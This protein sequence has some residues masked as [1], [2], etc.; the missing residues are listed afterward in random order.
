[1]N[2]L[3]IEDQEDFV[4]L[5]R[6]SAVQQG[7]NLITLDDFGIHKDEPIV[8]DGSLEEQLQKKFEEHDAKERISVVLLDT[9]LMQFRNQVSHSACRTALQSLGIPVCRYSKKQRETEL[10]NARRL[11]TIATEGSSSMLVPRAVIS[12]TDT[13]RLVDWLSQVGQSF[14]ALHKA[15]Q[16]LEGKAAHQGP[17]AL[18]AEI[19]GHP[20]ARFDFVGYTAQNLFFFG[21]QL[22]DE[23]TELE[24]AERKQRRL[25]TQLGYWLH[26]YILTFPGPILNV[27]AAAALLNLSEEALGIPD[28]DALLAP[29]K[30]AGPFSGLQSYYWANGVIDATAELDAPVWQD[31]KYAAYV[32]DSE[33]S[34]ENAQG[35]YCVLSN[36]AIPAAHAAAAPDW[37]PSGARMTR[38]EQGIYDKLSPL[39]SI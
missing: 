38:V 7:H 3:H 37:I 24:T 30:Y 23:Q 2:I 33:V 35:Y 21:K 29:A 27:S 9:D 8:G 16:G 28:L 36:K 26:N 13:T 6:T 5:V 25:A 32:L 19:L 14:E 20:D 39:L 17:A 1:M 18:L 10:S 11:T 34:P 15:V 22:P 4:S 31:E 12:E